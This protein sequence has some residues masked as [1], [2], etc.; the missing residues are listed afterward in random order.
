M[1][2]SI[3]LRRVRETRDGMVDSPLYLI[4]ENIVSFTGIEGGKTA[5]SV[6]VTNPQGTGTTYF[7]DNTPDE[8]QILIN[9]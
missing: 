1:A 3:K 2:K 9:S 4:T 5:I 7:V 6:V 8:V